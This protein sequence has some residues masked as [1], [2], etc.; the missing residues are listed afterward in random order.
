MMQFIYVYS[1][2]T[3]LI[4]RAYKVR[5]AALTLQAVQKY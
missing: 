2:I 4:T 3:S 5:T 1:R